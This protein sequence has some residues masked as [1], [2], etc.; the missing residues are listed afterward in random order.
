MYLSLLRLNPHSRRAMTEASRPYELHRSLLR[1]FPK[2]TTGGPVRILFR[3]DTD[4]ETGNMS[5]LVQSDRRPVWAQFNN[6]GSPVSE[7]KCKEYNPQFSSGQ[8]LRFRLR[9]NPTKRMNETGKRQGILREEEQ[10]EW[11]RNKGLKGGYELI[12]A[13]ALNERFAKDKKTDSL[14]V[15]RDITLLSVKFDGVLRVTD[16]RA[17]RV[18]LESGIGSAKGFGFGLLSIAPIKG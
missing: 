14:K 3:L 12:S 15:K 11:L 17:F 6:S 1:A 13:T 7:R 9:A 2:E 4:S 16:P 5:V 8:V 10:L 18:T